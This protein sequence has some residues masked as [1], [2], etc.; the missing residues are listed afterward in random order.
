MWGF[1]KKINSDEYEK[2]HKLIVDT[3]TKLDLALSRIARLEDVI[4]NV[5]ARVNR[6]LP[7]KDEEENKDPYNGTLAY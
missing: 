5:R 6:T 4:S 7:N 2:I 1:S 3:N